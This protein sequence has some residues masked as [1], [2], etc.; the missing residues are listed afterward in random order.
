MSAKASK[1]TKNTTPKENKKTKETKETV[2]SAS[3]MEDQD[4]HSLWNGRLK[5]NPSEAKTVRDFIKLLHQHIVDDD[6]AT[7]I[8]KLVWG[9]PQEVLD[10][11]ITKANKT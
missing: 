8:L 1:Q 5:R 3:D 2:T 10:S 7:E 11:L 9:E 6:G 4:Q